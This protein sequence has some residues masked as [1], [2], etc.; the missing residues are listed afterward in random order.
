MPRI[1]RLLTLVA[2]TVLVAVPAANGASELESATERL[3]AATCHACHSN[4][5]L[6]FDTAISI[7]TISF[8]KH[9]IVNFSFFSRA[10]ATFSK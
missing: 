9:C 5:L 8:T 4:L 7:F 2:L 3:F 6:S 10:L 1:K